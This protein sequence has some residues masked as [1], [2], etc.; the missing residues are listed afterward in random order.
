MQI[1]HLNILQNTNVLYNK[2]IKKQHVKNIKIV[3][4]TYIYNKSI[5]QYSSNN[6]IEDLNTKIPKDITIVQTKKEAENV[7]KILNSKKLHN[8]YHACDT[9]TMDINPKIQSPVGNG[10][11]ICLSI[12][13]G[14][15][16]NFGNG[17]YLWIDNYDKSNDILLYFKEYLEN[18]KILKI[19]HNYSFDRHVLYNHNINVKG[20]G[21][22]TLQMARLWNSSRTIDGGYSLEVLSK[23]LIPDKS[24]KETMLTLFGENIIRKDGNISKKIKLDE[25]IVLQTN[26]LTRLKW[27]QYSAQDS[28][29]TWHLHN[30]LIDELKL[31]P[32]AI[33][34]N[35]YDFYLKYWLPF[36]ELLT[37]MER[38][39]IYIRKDDY[40]PK[41]RQQAENDKKNVEKIFMNWAKEL[42]PEAK[43]MNPSSEQQKQQFFFGPIDVTND[44]HK[45]NLPYMRAFKT[46]NVTGYIEPGNKKPK[47]DFTFYLRGLGL[48][49]ISRTPRGL[50]QVSISVLKE[51]AGDLSNMTE[52][53][54][55]MY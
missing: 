25:P 18:P 45:S 20:F 26:E 21:G 32:W 51:L 27:I 37:D 28:C 36:G 39:G 19:W 24:I 1:K 55:G 38:L 5:R 33:N 48:P 22:D 13:C 42:L 9:E 30:K 14:P 53:K 6:S 3:N 47:K 43:Y 49:I 35:M 34:L 16:I 10:K 46:E 31:L 8:V 52:P 54:Y 7:Q 23:E 41:V 40:L 50:P 17:P 15:D 12:Y 2:C 4:N 29:T 11:V 44:I